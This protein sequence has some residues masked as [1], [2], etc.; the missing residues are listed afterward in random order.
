VTL[1]LAKQSLAGRADFFTWAIDAGLVSTNPVAS[2]RSLKQSR[3]VPKA[4]TSQEVYRLQRTAAGQ[5]QLAE[6]RG[7]GTK[8][9]NET[10]TPS[11]VAAL[12]S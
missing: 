8:D 12:M 5:R 6:A 2:V 9:K 11:L 10:A 7:I 1:S 4:I 3:R